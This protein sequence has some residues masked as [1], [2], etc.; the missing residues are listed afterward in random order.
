MIEPEPAYDAVFPGCST[1]HTARDRVLD[2]MTSYA[3]TTRVVTGDCRVTRLASPR[4]GRLASR[5][6]Y[7]KLVHNL[8]LVLH[9]HA[10][11]TMTHSASPISSEIKPFE[12]TTSALRPLPGLPPQFFI[13]RLEDKPQNPI[14]DTLR[15]MPTRLHAAAIPLAFRLPPELQALSAD[16]LKFVEARRNALESVWGLAASGNNASTVSRVVLVCSC[17]D[18][19]FITQTKST[20]ASARVG[21]AS[22]LL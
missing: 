9:R 22:V 5:P 18:Y 17:T 16:T 12:D 2:N 20:E 13:P 19:D 14:M 8:S 15:I 3:V 4:L 1:S 6:F 11:C 7:G 21:F 10:A